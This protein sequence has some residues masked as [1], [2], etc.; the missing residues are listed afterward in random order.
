MNWA[1]IA[2]VQSTLAAFAGA[3]FP[4]IAKGG[5][6]LTAGGW[7]TV[8][9]AAATSCAMLHVTAPRNQIGEG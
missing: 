7:A 6:P 9:L 8:L 1:A 2:P 4:I 3:L 5:I